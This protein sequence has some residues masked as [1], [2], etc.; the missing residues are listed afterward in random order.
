[1]NK[2]DTDTIYSYIE[3]LKKIFVVEE[4]VAWNPNLRS[5]T[6]IRT[7]NTRY[8]VDPSI[9]T[10]ALGVEPDLIV[11]DFDSCIPSEL[12][13][14]KKSVQSSASCKKIPCEIVTLPREKD[15]T[16]KI[17]EA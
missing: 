9:A 2:L 10:A 15:D 3:A 12:E 1:M 11:G 13:K 7:S 4:S 16:D 8:F 6:A 5:Q 14:Y 17:L